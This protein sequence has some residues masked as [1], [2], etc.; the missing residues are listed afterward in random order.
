MRLASSSL[1]LL[2][3][4]CWL[5]PAQQ[6]STSSKTRAGSSENAVGNVLGEKPS[7]VLEIVKVKGTVREIDLKARTVTI[8]PGKNESPLKLEFAQPTGR[9][10]IKTSKKAAKLLGKKKLKLEEL[11]VGSK[12]RL[13]YYPVLGQ[14][15]ELIVEQPAA[16]QG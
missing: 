2:V 14:V 6:Q 5:L 15:M 13:E 4:T 16:T 9:E 10:Q 7:A 8:V 3:M 12:V 1:W 11:G